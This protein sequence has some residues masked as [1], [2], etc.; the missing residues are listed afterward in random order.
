MSSRPPS[1]E[2]PDS[3]QA[4]PPDDETL[5]GE[6]VLGVLDRDARRQAQERSRQESG[7]AARVAGWERRLAPWLAEVAPVAVP[8]DLW[9]RL[10]SRLGWQESRPRHGLWNS[11]ALWRTAT[12]L[13]VL[14]AIALWAVHRPTPVNEAALTKPVT[15]LAQTNGAVGWLASVDRAAGTVLM[16]PVP[17][18]ADAQ[19]RIPELWVI[20]A[21]GPPLS[22]GAISISRSHTVTV[23]AAARAALGAPGSVL[24]VTLE[25]PAGVPHRAPSGPVIAQGAIRS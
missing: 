19:G 2:D 15:P 11:L 23:P 8:P 10:R 16:V 3:G 5:A 7:F 17:R 1:A 20:P 13:A 22:L 6:L 25:P 18:A 21:G 12:A 14:V 9:S 4:G 24:A